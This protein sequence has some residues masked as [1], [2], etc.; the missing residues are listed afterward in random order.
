MQTVKCPH[1][2]KPVSVDEV[3]THQ[4]REELVKTQ[5]ETFKKDLEK[6]KVEAALLA[7]QG[8]AKDF[9]EEKSRNKKLLFE[10]SHLNDEIRKLRRKDEERDLEMKKYLAGEEEKIRLESR[11]KALEEHELK[12]Q[13]KDKKLRDALKQIEEMKTRIEQGSQQTQGEV[14]ELE[15]EELLKKEFPTDQI[16]EVKKGVRGADVLQ[17]VVDKRGQKCGTILWESKNAT[18]SG[19][20]I[21]KL[22]EDQRAAHADLAV[23]VATNP[24]DGTETFIFMDG[25]WI[26]TR[27]MAIPL[28]L[29]LRFDLVR[30]NFER[31]AVD[32]KSEKMEILYSYITSTEF[33]HRVEGIVEAF[34]SQQEELEREKRWFST[35]WARQEKTIRSVLDHTH[36]MY[37]DLQSLVGK[38]LPE[39][40]SLELDSGD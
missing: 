2:G 4:I 8:L 32:G 5:G 26:T 15:L 33:R 10:L 25:V 29:A 18:W 38:Q 35:K 34:T 27:K 14:L 16:S 23:L 9:E 21:G 17:T 24:P 22:K 7:T 30:I 36:G 19:G 40:K 28:A 3:L 31:G 6:A 11:K 20:W 39:I 12:D 37:G 13:E 1:C